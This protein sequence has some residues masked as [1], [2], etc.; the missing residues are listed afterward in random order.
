M[1]F[2]SSATGI[3]SISV[4]LG[5]DSITKTALK[6][7]VG[8]GT[9]SP[10]SKLDVAGAVTEDGYYTATSGGVSL[11]ANGLWQQG[12]GHLTLAS[13]AILGWSGAVNVNTDQPGDT[14][15]QR[16]G[17]GQLALRNSTNS[18]TFNLYS[19]YTDSNNYQRLRITPSLIASE[20]LGTGAQ[21]AI[22]VQGSTVT[23]RSGTSTS[24]RIVI[25]TTGLV[26]IGVTG[27]TGVGASKVTVQGGDVEVTGI[28]NGII[29]ADDV[30]NRRRITITSGGSLVVSAPLA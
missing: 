30:G 10:T 2:G 29:L 13:G 14:R 24:N 4:V 6:G 20:G 22:T 12:T 16:D 26:G 25:N 11:V 21:G 27:G 3:G 1:V 28:G 18:Q 5:N 23:V 7:N 19:T 17:A 8:I 9:T 15:L